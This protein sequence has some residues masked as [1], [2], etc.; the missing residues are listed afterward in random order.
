MTCIEHGPAD[1]QL[2]AQPP[3][4]QRQPLLAVVEDG[5]AISAMLRPICEFLD[6]GV[7]Q[8]P[9]DGDLSRILRDFCPMAVVAELDCRGQDGCHVMITVADYDRTLP[10]LLLTG[11]EAALAGAADAV[12]EVWCLESV[13]KVPGFPSMAEIVNFIF[14]A[15]RKGR[16][17]RMVRV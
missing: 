7:E 11:P 12:E 8:I 6:I 1:G 9:S 4:P 13:L 17:M 15:G 16:C 3:T 5:D 2:S 10:I 14:T